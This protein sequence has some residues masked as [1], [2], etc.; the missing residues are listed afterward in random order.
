MRAGENFLK[1]LE[2]GVEV[3]FAD[4]PDV[5]GAMGK[6]ILTQ[7]AQPGLRLLGGADADVGDRFLSPRENAKLSE[8]ATFSK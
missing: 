2:S 4:L 7:K 3:L 1:L 6:F 8:S 5:S